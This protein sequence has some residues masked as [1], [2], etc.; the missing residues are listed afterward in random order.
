MYASCIPLKVQRHHS[1]G[2]DAEGRQERRSMLLQSQNQ[3]P[4]PLVERR[5]DLPHS[6]LELDARVKREREARN[7]RFS[8]VQSKSIELKEIKIAL[9][10]HLIIIV[11][12]KYEQANARVLVYEASI[13]VRPSDSTCSFSVVNSLIIIKIALYTKRRGN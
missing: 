3:R 5:A 1:G 9:I 2:L 13:S 12:K 4:P 7:R 11:Y 8:R 10:N 6:E